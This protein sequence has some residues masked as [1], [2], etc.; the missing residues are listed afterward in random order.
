MPTSIRLPEGTEK[1]LTALAAKTGR[2]KAFYIRE[3][4]LAYI[5]DL[6]DAYLAEKIVDRVR[7]SE[8]RTY[9]L[10]EVERELGLED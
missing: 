4:I 9:T 10:T 6:E 7:K 5:D 2:S 3:A 1:R 8:E